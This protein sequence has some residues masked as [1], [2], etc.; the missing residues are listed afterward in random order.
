MT[1]RPTAAGKSSFDLI[2]RDRFFAALNLSEGTVLLDAGCGTGLYT[3]AAAE[4]IG[5]AGVIYAVDLWKEGIASL[6]REVARRRLT[7][8]HPLVADVSKRIP[9]PDQSV[10]VC[11]VATVLHD[12]AQ[13][14]TVEGAL[15]EMGRV[16]KPEGLLAVVEFEKIDGPPGPPRAIRLSPAGL[17]AV[18]APHGY[19]LLATKPV[20]PYNYLSLYRARLLL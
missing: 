4:R 10:D 7:N 3:L 12:L 14:G 1:K 2:D 8:V 15:R 18:L 20:G 16:L 13:D 11:L 9:L 17:D 5:T 19:R 6:S